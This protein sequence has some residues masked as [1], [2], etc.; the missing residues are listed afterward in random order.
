METQ[1]TTPNGSFYLQSSEVEE[2]WLFHPPVSSERQ[3]DHEFHLL[4]CLLFIIHWPIDHSTMHPRYDNLARK[5][6][7]CTCKDCRIICS[8]LELLTFLGFGWYQI[9]H[10]NWRSREAYQLLQDNLFSTTFHYIFF[11]EF[12]VCVRSLVDLFLYRLVPYKTQ[13][14]CGQQ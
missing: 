5:I 10:P 6:G 13:K 14:S 2:A 9:S 1:S 4:I 8:V 3:A 12:D 11:T 7:L